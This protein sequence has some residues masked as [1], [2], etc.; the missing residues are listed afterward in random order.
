MMNMIELN[1]LFVISIVHRLI[2]PMSPHPAHLQISIKFRPRELRAFIMV[3]T[4]DDEYSKL[5]IAKTNLSFFH[6]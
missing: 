6:Q 5:E 4:V 2:Y 1:L 3:V